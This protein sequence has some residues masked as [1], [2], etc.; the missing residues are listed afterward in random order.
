MLVKVK[1]TA[2]RSPFYS[3]GN[4]E[5]EIIINY[6]EMRYDN[7]QKEWSGSGFLRGPLAREY[8]RSVVPGLDGDTRSGH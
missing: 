1:I 4:D 6:A 3:S 8:L 5:V 2:T 7:I